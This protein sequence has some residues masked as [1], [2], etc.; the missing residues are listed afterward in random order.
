MPKYIGDQLVLDKT[1]FIMSPPR[2]GSTLFRNMLNG[3]PKLYSPPELYL[4]PYDTMKQRAAAYRAPS[5]QYLK[6]GLIQTFAELYEMTYQEAAALTKG[7]EDQDA[8]TIEAYALIQS[9]IGDDVLVDKT[10]SNVGNLSNLLM[11]VERFDKPIF[12]H[13]YRHPYSAVDSYLRQASRD[14]KLSKKTFLLEVG[15]YTI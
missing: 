14:F 1:I 10:P 4:L 11:A 3:H 2:S 12:F 9:Q 13:L 5:K 7:L 15:E 8:S 6:K